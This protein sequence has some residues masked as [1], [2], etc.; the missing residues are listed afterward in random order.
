MGKTNYLFGSLIILFVSIA[1]ATAFSQS[2]SNLIS[3]AR[4]TSDNAGVT[5]FVDE[6]LAPTVANELGALT[7]PLATAESV[8]YLL[9]PVGYDQDWHPAPTRQWI[10]VLS[11]T[12]EIEVQDGEIRTLTAGSIIFV[13]DITGKGHK[14]RNVGNETIVIAWVPVGP[15]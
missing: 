3:Y 14:T 10:F 13:E 2:A 6:Q 5:H 12:G 7:T 8:G 4:V 1:S 11:G 15:G 9:L